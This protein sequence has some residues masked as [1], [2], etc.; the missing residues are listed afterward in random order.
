MKCPD[1]IQMLH[2]SPHH[3]HNTV[4]PDLTTLPNFH[5][6]AIFFK[7]PKFPSQ[8]YVI[9]NASVTGIQTV[10]LNLVISAF[11]SCLW[12]SVLTLTMP[13]DSTPVLHK[14]ILLFQQWMV[15]VQHDQAHP[16]PA[17]DRAV[18][19]I[20]TPRTRFLWKW[21]SSLKLTTHREAN[22]PF[23]LLWREDWDVSLPVICHCG[24]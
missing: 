22:I 15:S 16:L 1:Y 14:L 23:R 3:F 20:M 12:F 7:S 2:P 10:S 13:Y 17:W 24:W 19:D 8:S 9:P 21:S 4:R 5:N 18:S 11:K 6:S